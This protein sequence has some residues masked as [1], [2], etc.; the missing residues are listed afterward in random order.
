MVKLSIVI[1]SWNTK[2][3]LKQCLESLKRE[4]QTV[5]GAEIIVVDNGSSDGSPQMVEA[6]FPKVKLIKNKENLGFAK[7]NNL[8]LK[9]AVGKYIMLLNSDTTVGKG[10]LKV[11]VTF[12]EKNGEDNLALSPLLMLPN[13]QPQIDY[14]MHFPNFWQIFLYHH[15][16]W[17]PIALRVG[18]V[19][20]L[21][22]QEPAKEPFEVEQLPGAAIVASR[23]VW[24]EVGDLDKDYHFLFEDVDWSWRAQKKG[25]KL[26][27]IPEAEVVHFGGGSWR[28]KLKENAS[29]FYYQFF[30]SFLLF[31]Q[32]NYGSRA[33]TFYKWAIISSFFLT[34][35]PILAFKFWW[36]NGR[37][38]NLWG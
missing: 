26:I 17:R 18:P 7:G 13:A 8:G 37:Q 9:E 12:L 5:G 19:R 33:R 24:Q 14:F 34:L 31:V 36:H 32:K 35:K 22:A 25:I 2:E 1:L 4:I 21:I 29:R 16:L 11:L 10:A 28:K 3:L 6:A 38:L 23:K 15:P 20:S 27:V 30:A